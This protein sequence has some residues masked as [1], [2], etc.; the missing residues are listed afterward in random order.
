MVMSDDDSGTRPTLVR[1]AGADRLRRDGWRAR[2]Y[3]LRASGVLAAV[4]IPL[5]AL[6]Y[7][8]R[9]GLPLATRRAVGVDLALPGVAVLAVAVLCLIGAHRI[10]SAMAVVESEGEPPH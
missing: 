1:A 7:G 10:R 6:R 9:L 5:L 4:A 3:L 8:D 2:A